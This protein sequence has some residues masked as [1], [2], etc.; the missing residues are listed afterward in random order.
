[1]PQV[2]YAT[3]PTYPTYPEFPIWVAFDRHTGLGAEAIIAASKEIGVDP[4]MSLWI[5]F[6]IEGSKCSN[7]TPSPYWDKYLQCRL[8]LIKTLSALIIAKISRNQKKSFHILPSNF[9]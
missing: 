5:A 6:Y 1:V 8:W 7:M 4:S 3:Q 9:Q 2:Q